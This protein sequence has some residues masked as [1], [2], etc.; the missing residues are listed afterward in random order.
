MDFLVVRFLNK[1]EENILGDVSFEN[2]TIDLKSTNT[3]HFR[4]KHYV[5]FSFLKQ[6]LKI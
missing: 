6:G 5:A 4:I 3:W 1:G 2:Q